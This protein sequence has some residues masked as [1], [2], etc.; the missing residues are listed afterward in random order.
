MDVIMGMNWLEF[1]HV[2]INCYNKN[3]WFLALED[4]Q[5]DDFISAKEL[6]ELL[7]DESK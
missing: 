1:N 5:E 6:K 7:K 3:L 4:K 2:Y